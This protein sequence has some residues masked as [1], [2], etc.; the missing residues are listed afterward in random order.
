MGEQIKL[1]GRLPY[2]KTREMYSISDIILLPSIWQEPFSGIPLETA[3][4]EKLI[5]ASNTGGT[6]DS[7][8]NDSFWTHLILIHGK[9]KFN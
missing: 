4:A 3:S 2:E 8:V 1:L 7:V 6:V 9:T 5:I